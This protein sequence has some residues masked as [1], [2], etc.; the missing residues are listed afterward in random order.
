MPGLTRQ[1]AHTQA[2]EP[3]VFTRAS[4]VLYNLAGLMQFS[5]A[6]CIVIFTQQST[7]CTGK[8]KLLLDPST[9]LQL[10]IDRSR[11]FEANR[12]ATGLL[13][14]LL[15]VISRTPNVFS[16]CAIWLKQP[17]SQP[18]R[19]PNEHFLSAAIDRK[20]THSPWPALP[21]LE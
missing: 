17:I 12:V 3:H 18:K 6:V 4:S 5:R 16:R 13:D 11:Q 10:H 9:K 7:P 15:A 20:R 21:V 14:S 19:T 1:L 2:V 8:F